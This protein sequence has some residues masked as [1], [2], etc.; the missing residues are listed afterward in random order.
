MKM[1]EVIEVT[2]L[3]YVSWCNNKAIA[4][5]QYIANYCA[6]RTLECELRVDALDYA[7]IGK[8]FAE[9]TPGRVPNPQQYCDYLAGKLK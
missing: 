7:G 2:R 3:A 8:N 4:D 6:L 5:T 1:E 9:K